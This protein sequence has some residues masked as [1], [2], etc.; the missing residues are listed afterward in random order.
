MKPTVLSLFAGIGGFDLGLER[1]GYQVV[2]QCEIDPFCR[3]VLKKH[4]PDIWLHDDVRTLTGDIVREHC[5]AVDV[6]CGGYPC[7]PFSL[8]GKRKGTD[9]ERHLWPH[10]AR[11][12]CD[13][14]PRLALLENVPGHLSMG[15]GDVLG[16]L[17]AMGYHAQWACF[18]ASALGAWHRRNRLFVVAHTDCDWQQQ[19]QGTFSDQWRWVGDGG[20]EIAVADATGQRPPESRASWKPFDPTT[21]IFGEATEFINGGLGSEWRFEPDVGRVA[22][23]VPNRVDRLRALGNAI[24]PPVAEYVGRCAL[25]LLETT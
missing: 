17:A 19:S 11:I 9:D 3:K 13:L 6:I 15:F 7:Q 8:A 16:D 24:C 1:A 14:R 20:E 21:Q 5:G 25:N 2:G 10:F 22:H 4:W 12:V 23:G 18:P